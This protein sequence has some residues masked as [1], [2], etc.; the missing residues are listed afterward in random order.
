[1][2]KIFILGIFLAQFL[3]VTA[4][5]F[6]FG[7]RVIISQPVYGDLYVGGENITINAPVYGDLV[8]AGGTIIINDT[9][10]NDILLAGGTVLFNGYVGDDIR[11]TGGN[12]RISKNVTGDVLVAGGEV[13]VDR[14]VTIGG[15]AFCGGRITVNGNVDGAVSGIVGQLNLNGDI[16]KGITYRGG[17]LSI[18]GSV[19]DTSILGAQYIILGDKAVFNKDVRYWS[20]QGKI[21]FSNHMKNAKAIYDPALR[22]ENAKWYFLGMTS[23]FLLLWYL[24]MVLL[25]ILIIQYLFPRTLKNAANNVFD[26]PLKSIGFGCLFFIGVPV[27]AGITFLT[28]VGM[29]V[30][31]LLIFAYLVLVLLATVITAVVMANW[32][33]NRFEM[34]CSYWRLAFAAFWIFV[35]LKLITLMPVIG[36][37][38]V[39]LLI[40][41]C[42][43]AIVLS[44]S[45][46][47]K[48][49]VTI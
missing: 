23:V 19:G 48:S 47:K 17:T 16:A 22:V 24:G 30:S 35:A 41:A 33:N 39:I 2:K 14:G 10:E 44:I 28:L 46:R 25:M 29:P 45:W 15:L 3:P 38:I 31:I 11:C 18:N 6:E 43:G 9:V 21:D 32:L 37:I 7:S 13:V 26:H 20:E 49:T 4:F 1:M 8:I 36:W 5:H 42:F 34:K 27:A 40:C 12:I